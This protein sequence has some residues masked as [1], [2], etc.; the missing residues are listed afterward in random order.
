MN[1]NDYTTPQMV[2]IKLATLIQE[3]VN[4]STLFHWAL[5]GGAAE[6]ELFKT[7]SQEPFRSSIAWDKVRIYS[8]Y[9][10]LGSAAPSRL[11]TVRKYLPIAPEHLLEPSS[12]A[13]DAQTEATRY[14]TLLKGQVPH[15]DSMPRFD[16]AL[17]EI[18][19]DGGTA[20]V[21]PQQWD[22]FDTDLTV[23]PNEVK[24]DESQAASQKL[25]TL[26]LPA[27]EESKKIVFLVLG[28]DSRFAV[29]DILNLQPEARDYPANFLAAKAPWAHLYADAQAM[30]EKSYSIY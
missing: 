22:L 9:Q 23:A 26:T 6:E 24:T 30:R 17:L 15:L 5:S 18:R 14:A 29:G 3:S 16:L 1:Y 13:S 7:L 4:Q 10:E 2:T 25:I 20:G 19:P 12:T 21:Y 8:I 11:D 28:P 27:L